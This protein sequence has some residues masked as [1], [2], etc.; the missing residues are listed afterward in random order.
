VQDATAER[1]A[2]GVGVVDVKGIH[3][4]GDCDEEPEVLFAERLGERDVS[5]RLEVVDARGHNFLEVYPSP[6]LCSGSG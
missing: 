5:S 3:V 6:S 1:R 4:A 2:G